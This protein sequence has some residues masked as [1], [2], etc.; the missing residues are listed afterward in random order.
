M[1]KTSSPV[2]PPGQNAILTALV[3]A[4][5][6][7]SSNCVRAQGCFF[8]CLAPFHAHPEDVC[9]CCCCDMAYS[10]QKCIPVNTYCIY[11][12][13]C[14]RGL[15]FHDRLIYFLINIL[16]TLHSPKVHG[17]K[18]HPQMRDSVA[19]FEI[20]SGRVLSGRKQQQLSFCKQSRDVFLFV[21]STPYYFPFF[22]EIP[23]QPNRH[24]NEREMNEA[25]FLF[26][27]IRVQRGF[28]AYLNASF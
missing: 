3:S 9:I 7:K 5:I 23:F 20:L 25:G 27:I 4:Y 24:K 19:C 11:L 18:K 21:S 14:T 12:V 8:V 1:I 6:L 28:V 16:I 13:H 26:W 22:C 10:S 17:S 2:G 15:R